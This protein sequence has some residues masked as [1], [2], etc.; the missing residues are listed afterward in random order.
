M[1]NFNM[2]ETI[3]LVIFL[4]GLS[5]TRMCFNPGMYISTGTFHT[6]VPVIDYCN[7]FVNLTDNL[8]T[9]LDDN[10]FSHMIYLNQA[11]LSDNKISYVS[12]TAFSGT[13]LVV[14]DL[15][16][17]DIS[18]FPNLLAVAETLQQLTI[19]SN[20]IPEINPNLVY[21]LY[22][23]KFLFVSANF[24]TTFPDAAGENLLPLEY[25]LYHYCYLTEFIDI[26]R[27]SSTMKYLYASYNPIYDSVDGF[28]NTVLQEM[29]VLEYLAISGLN[30]QVNMLLIQNSKW[31]P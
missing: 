1:F 29:A 12:D 11:D 25:L 15:S 14:L 6:V 19:Y 31:P 16:I 10:Q 3:A 30:I 20:V 28:I 22:S 24:L 2:W 26:R 23:L 21:G 8:I 13:S 17:N 27:Y 5:E 18:S 7:Y 4:S 9:S